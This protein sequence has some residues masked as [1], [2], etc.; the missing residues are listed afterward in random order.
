MTHVSKVTNEARVHRGGLETR[1]AICKV[2][3]P[4]YEEPLAELGRLQDQEQAYRNEAAENEHPLADY[5]KPSP[6]LRK[7]KVVFLELVKP[8]CLCLQVKVTP[9]SQLGAEEADTQLHRQETNRELFGLLV[10]RTGLFLGASL[11]GLLNPSFAACVDHKRKHPL[12]VAQ[13]RT[14]PQE[15]LLGHIYGLKL[16]RVVGQHNF[17]LKRICKPIGLITYETAPLEGELSLL[18]YSL[19]RWQNTPLFQRSF[20]I[21][22]THVEETQILT[23][24]QE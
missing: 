20:A 9:R 2:H 10:D 1:S 23:A 4:L 7:R 8:E 15:L 3:I 17:S 22:T 16:I 6:Q 14:S 12:S 24:L 5:R 19:C 13:S 18:A 21:E 11:T